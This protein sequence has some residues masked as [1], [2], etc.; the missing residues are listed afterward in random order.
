MGAGSASVAMFQRIIP[1]PAPGPPAPPFDPT[2]AENG[3]SV[4]PVSGRIVLGNDV[5][6]TS[7]ALLTNRQ[8]PM[9]G[10]H[11][12]LTDPGF[13]TII[14]AGAYEIDDTT[15]SNSFG[16][17]S[18]G[19]LTLETDDPLFNPKINIGNSTINQSYQIKQRADG[20]N[21]TDPGN[22]SFFKID[23]VNRLFEFGDLQPLGNNN[24]FQID[25]V[26]KSTTAFMNG[27]RVILLDGGPSIIQFG[28]LDTVFSGAF[29]EMDLVSG[30]FDVSIAGFNALRLTNGDAHMQSIGGAQIDLITTGEI[31][32]SSP[33]TAFVSIN[34]VNG[35]TGTVLNPVTI[36]V[37][38]GIVTNV[39]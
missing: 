20:L 2:S 15:A 27:G 10:L 9:S 39:A 11:I 7:A 26:A 32:M 24:K 38:G 8:L 4:D 25:D 36:T 31:R 33:A 34:G 13:Q 19:F 21:I 1:A 3:L 28:D 29:F 22:N 5:G 6:G 35:F 30:T 37:D 16:L 17:L 12:L 23:Q 18:T 14:T